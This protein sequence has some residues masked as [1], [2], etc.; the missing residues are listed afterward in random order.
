MA[1]NNQRRR[2][3]S[4]ATTSNPPLDALLASL[5]PGTSCFLDVKTNRTIVVLKEFR[6]IS[7]IES[8]S[9]DEPIIPPWDLYET[10]AK[11]LTYA[12]I[13]LRGAS[14]KLQA[15]S[16][17]PVMMKPRYFGYKPNSRMWN[18]GKKN[19]YGFAAP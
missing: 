9:W 19:A 5:P 4:R 14:S 7:P 18:N 2:G 16:K 13:R 1:T 3:T 11:K 8:I 15:A 10:V 6:L 17:K 12:G